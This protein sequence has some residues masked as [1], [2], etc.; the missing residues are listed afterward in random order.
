MNVASLKLCKE[1]YELSGWN[2]DSESGGRWYGWSKKAQLYVLDHAPAED[3]KKPAF[4]P[5]YNLGYLFR[6]LPARY[7]HEDEHRWDALHLTKWDRLKNGG[8]VYFAEYWTPYKSP[9]RVEAGTPEDA[10]AK[11]AIELFKQGILT[12]QPST[13]RGETV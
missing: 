5:A 9:F 6:R 7:W 8:I 13:E 2:Y 12:N 3:Y 1:L 4:I 11:L 10:L